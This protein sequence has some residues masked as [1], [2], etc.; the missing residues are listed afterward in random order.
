LA[1]TEHGSS[2][3]IQLQHPCFGPNTGMNTTNPMYTGSMSEQSTATESW[4]PAPSLTSEVLS[5]DISWFLDFD[6][7]PTNGDAVAREQIDGVR[8]Q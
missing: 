4:P 5:T 1:V 6:N 7:D 3:T 2:N 8:R